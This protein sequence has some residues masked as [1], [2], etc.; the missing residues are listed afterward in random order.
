MSKVRFVASLGLAMMLC[1]E[2]FLYAQTAVPSVAPLPAQILSA[3]KVFISNASGEFAS[4]MWSGGMDRTYNEFY[5]ATKSWGHYELVQ[6]PAD[7]D[8]VFEIGLT[9]ASPYP[10][11]KLRILDPKTH[12]VLWT[13]VEYFSQAASKNTRD[14]KFDGGIDAVVN[15]LKTLVSRPAVAVQ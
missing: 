6:S 7:A 12:I 13:V 11:F 10:S 9:I 8:I 15:D 2:S 14:K 3:K 1:A 4:D 5:A